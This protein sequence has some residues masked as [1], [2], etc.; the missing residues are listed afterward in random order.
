MTSKI[1]YQK[2]YTELGATYQLVLPLSLEGLFPDDD[3]VR[4]PSAGGIGRGCGKPCPGQ[5]TV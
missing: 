2:D 4:I 3:S 1:S 5:K